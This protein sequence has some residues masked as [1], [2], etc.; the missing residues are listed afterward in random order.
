MGLYNSFMK[1]TEQFKTG[2]K[3]APGQLIVIQGLVNTLDIESGVDEIATRELLKAW[4]LRHDLIRPG[5]RISATD[6]R[7]A[8]TLREA[9]RSLLMA[10][11]GDMSQASTLKRINSLFSRFPLLVSIDTDATPHLIASGHGIKGLFGFILSHIIMA[12]ND[13]T[14]FRLKACSESNCQWA[15]YDS[16][17]NRSGRWCSMSVCG[18]REKARTYRKRQSAKRESR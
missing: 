3:P 8:L 14:W 10:N 4:L 11:N 16:S 12:L 15:F 13:G 5:D 6:W 17:K 18:S 2:G 9:L 7:T 1:N